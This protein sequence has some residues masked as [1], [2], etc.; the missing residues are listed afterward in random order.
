VTEQK[1]GLIQKAEKKAEE[2]V[3]I[4]IEKATKVV[5]KGIDKVADAAISALGGKPVKQSS[6][7]GFT[8][9]YHGQ[10]ESR[11]EDR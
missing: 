1:Q 6:D 7:S 11:D 8:S 9:T 10:Q 4:G 5:D 2:A 3:D